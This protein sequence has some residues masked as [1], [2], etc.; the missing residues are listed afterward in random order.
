MPTA[1]YEP[2]TSQT[3]GSDSGTITISSIPSTYT[4]LKVIFSDVQLNAAN[5]IF[6]IYNN[7]TT[8]LYSNITFRGTSTLTYQLN[9]GQSYQRINMS[10]GYPTSSS[11]Y[12]G[13][14]EIDIFSYASTSVF[15]TS[16]CTY[17]NT[18]G[19]G[20]DLG[21][22]ASIW[23]STSAINRLDFVTDNTT[24]VKFLT[25]TTVTLYGIKAE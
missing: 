7:D 16:L 19:S 9:T 25:G 22:I 14:A 3:L 23:R 24:S 2:I 6:Y 8:A 21:G 18:Q 5:S 11:V 1:T 10:G 4:D 13:W 15:K 17:N 20:G 12:F